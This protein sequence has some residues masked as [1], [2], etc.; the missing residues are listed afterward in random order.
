VPGLISKTI[1]EGQRAGGGGVLDYDTAKA[2]QQ[3]VNAGV[4]RGPQVT[5]SLPNT[6]Q[7]LQLNIFASPALPRPSQCFL[8]DECSNTKKDYVQ[9]RRDRGEVLEQWSKARYTA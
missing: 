9:D 4:E 3:R 7:S 2:M 6:D 1:L 5:S 8:C